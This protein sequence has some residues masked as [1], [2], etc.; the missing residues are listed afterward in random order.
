MD[1]SFISRNLNEGFSGGEKKRCEILQ[2][3]VL[4]PEFAI[5]DETDSG[6]DIDAVR[7]VANAV[8]T[9]Y[10]QSGGQMGFLI[11][12]HYQR[13]LRYIKPLHKVHVMMDGRVVLS[14]GPELAEELEE[15]GY[16]WLEE[17]LKAEG[18]LA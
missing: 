4:E 7:I 11:I 18:V 12:T 1:P 3:A 15:K 14:G 2:L 17:K 10:E 8:N 16:D 5:M 13:I 9:I 6:L